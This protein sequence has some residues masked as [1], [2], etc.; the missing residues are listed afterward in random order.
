M[1]LVDKLRESR[2][3]STV[4]FMEFIKRYRKDALFC[5][6]EGEDSKYYGSRVQRCCDYYNVEFINSG[7]KSEVLRLF[8][9]ISDKT[10]YN[11]AHLLYF[12]DR[13]FDAPVGRPEIYETPCYS[14]ENLYTSDMVFSRILKSEFGLTE[15]DDDYKKCVEFFKARQTEFHE[16]ILPLN[17]WIA[18]QRDISNKGISSRVDLKNFNVKKFV[19]I[20]LDK[21]VPMYTIQDIERLFPESVKV[22]QIDFDLKVME[23]QQCDKQ[24]VFRGKFEIVFFRLF[25]ELLKTDRCSK[26][27]KFFTSKFNVKLALTGAN[28]ISELSVYAENPDCLGLYVINRLVEYLTQFPQYNG[29][30]SGLTIAK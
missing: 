8:R 20:S 11:E 16:S 18:C 30:A 24:K 10:E 6:V 19:D 2:H 15:V 23:L 5:F 3:T 22:N 21:V 13:D 25:L 26:K 12:I 1:N 27:P 9:I 14:V 29:P 17:A 28:L 7:G 4:K